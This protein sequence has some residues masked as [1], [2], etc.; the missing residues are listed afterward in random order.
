MSK[1]IHL[2]D[3]SR[4][5]LISQV[6][7]WGYSEFYANQ[8]WDNLYKGLLIAPDEMLGLK[9]ELLSRLTY[10]TVT[11]TLTLKAEIRSRDGHTT[12]YLLNGHDGQSIETV[13]MH[14]ENRNTACVS[15]QV[16]CAM[17]CVF[18]ATGQMGYVRHLSAGEIVEQVLFVSRELARK[19]AALRNVVFM[20]MGEPLHNY[21]S[22]MAAVDII[23]DD[24]GLGLGH[25]RITLSTV[26]IPAAIRRMADEGRQINLAVSLHAAT[27]AER[28]LLVPINRRWTLGELLESCRYYSLKTDRRIFFE[29]A[30]IQGENDTPE[31]AHSLGKALSNL[32]AHVNLIPLNP[33]DGYDGSASSLASAREFQKILIEY[34]LPSTIRQRRGID[35]DAGCGQLRQRIELFNN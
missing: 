4:S 20:G 10:E 7:D 35:I 27:D 12:K 15:T 19:A 16:G 34:Q 33:T 26:G 2:Y 3:L 17:G 21:E 11:K 1:R 28:S 9:S 14:Y 5:S 6:A 29:W 30:L 25:R 13:L 23:T 24:K 22:S 31:Q 8:L 32:R 18:C